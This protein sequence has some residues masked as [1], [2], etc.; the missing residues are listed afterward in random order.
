MGEP[1]A[2]AVGMRAAFVDSATAGE[3]VGAF[4]PRSVGHQEIASLAA[5]VERVVRREVKSVRT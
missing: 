3:W 2:P 4:A 1:V 5:V